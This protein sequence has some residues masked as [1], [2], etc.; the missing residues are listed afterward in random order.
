VSFLYV[1]ALLIVPAE[2]VVGRH[3]ASVEQQLKVEVHWFVEGV[4]SCKLVRHQL[5]SLCNNFLVKV[6]VGLLLTCV[7]SFIT[8]KL[9]FVEKYVVDIE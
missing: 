5:S 8:E 7:S 9:K 1:V 6:R 4:E 2:L 3:Q